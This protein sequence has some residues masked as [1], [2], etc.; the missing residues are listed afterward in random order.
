MTRYGLYLPPSIGEKKS[1]RRRSFDCSIKRRAANGVAIARSILFCCKLPRSGGVGVEGISTA[2][3]SD[4][5]KNHQARVR[6]DDPSA[7][8]NA[9]YRAQAARNSG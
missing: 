8:S 4:E 3:V 2:A 5:L 9:P 6:Y 1:A 7:V